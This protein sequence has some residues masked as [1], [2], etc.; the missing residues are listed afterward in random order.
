MG[1]I[2]KKI[3]LV[4]IMSSFLLNYTVFH[5]LNTQDADVY[6]TTFFL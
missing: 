4:Y 6:Y 3:D 5:E 1:S 2:S